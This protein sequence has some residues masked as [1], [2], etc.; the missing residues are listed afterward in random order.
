MSDAVLQENGMAR[1]AMSDREM[2][3]IASVEEWNK[4]LPS[5]ALAHKY[6]LI[7]RSPVSF[8]Q[9]TN[10]LFWA[11][12]S[13]DERLT[14]FG[15]SRTV[16]WIVGDCSTS[17]F[18][19][20]GSDSEG[21]MYGL[22]LTD[23]SVIADYQ[24]DVWRLATS[25][26][27]LAR[28]N[29]AAAGS[30]GAGAASAAGGA[31]GGGGGS[32]GGGAAEEAV[33][34]AVVLAFARK[35]LK[36]I[37]GF[38]QG[39]VKGGAGGEGGAEGA[40]ARKLS[41]VL[42]MSGGNMK[43]RLVRFLA[44]VERE[45]SR[46]RLLKKW[47]VE[48]GGRW[49]FQEHPG[50][51]QACPKF[52]EDAVVAALASYADGVNVKGLARSMHADPASCGVSRYM[53][54]TETSSG[55]LHVLDVRMQQRPTAYHF[56]N[57]DERRAYRHRFPHET[58]RFLEASAA[59]C[60][61]HDSSSIGWMELQEGVH[62]SA[63]GRYSVRD[64]SPYEEEYPAAVSADVKSK[65]KGFALTTQVMVGRVAMSAKDVD[66]AFQGISH[67]PGL[68]VWRLDQGKVV[69][70]PK[71]DH[72]KFYTRDIYIV[73]KTS[74]S[75]AAGGVTHAVHYWLGK[76]AS[77]ED[78]S[79]AALKALDLD[80]AVGG[81]STQHR[82]Q[83]G[84]ESPLFLSYFRPCIIPI[85]DGASG[86]R[87][88]YQVK[89]R[90]FLHVRQ[91]AFAR[92]S[93]N[94]SD[95]FVLQAPSKLYQ[96]NGANVSKQE[97]IR[98]ADATL[99]L[100]SQSP[101]GSMPVA[102]IDDGKADDASSSEFWDLFGGFAPIA[103]KSVSEEDVE[104]KAVPPTLYLVTSSGL[105]EKAK[106]P[107]KKNLLESSKCYLLDTGP[108]LFVWFGKLS[109][110]PDRRA[111]CVA[112][113]AHMSSRPPSVLVT[114]MS[115]RSE[116]AAFKAAF[117]EWPLAPVMGAG[118]GGASKLKGMVDKAVGRGPQAAAGAAEP[119]PP[120]LADVAGEMKK[121]AAG[122][123]E[124]PPP[125]LA[126]VAGEMQVWRVNGSNKTL[127]AAEE[128]GRFHG[129]DCYIVQYTFT[130]DRKFEY[131][132]FLW[133][134]RD[135]TQ[136]E[137]TSA[138]AVATRAVDA[139]RGNATLV[140]VVQGREPEQFISLFRT[141]LFFLKGGSSAS[142]KAKI[143]G[144]G[145]SDDTYDPAGVALFRVRARGAASTGASGAALF[146]AVQMDPVAKSLN[147]ED[148]FLLQTPTS[149]FLWLGNGSSA[150]DK[151]AVAAAA[152]IIKPGTLVKQ[153][154]EGKETSVFW[155]HLGSKVEYPASREG[156]EAAR[157]GRLFQV[158]GSGDSFKVL[159]VPGYSQD[160][161]ISED[162]MLL[163][164]YTEVFAWAGVNV[165]DKEKKEA[166]NHALRYV[167]RVA[168]T[169][170]RSKDTT[171]V[172]VVE[173]YEPPM[174]TALFP[175]WDHAAS[176]ALADPYDRKLA[177]LQGK[178]LEL[179]DTAKRRLAA[180]TH[181]SPSATSSSS[182][183]RS[184]S[185]P[186]SPSAKPSLSALTISPALIKG[187]AGRR[188]PS[189]APSPSTQRAAAMA[190]LTG[191]L[192]G[193]NLEPLKLARGNSL[194]G[195][196]HEA[197]NEDDD[198][199]DGEEEGKKGGGGSSDSA[200][201]AGGGAGGAGAAGNGEAAVEGV[202]YAFD[203]LIID[204]KNPIRGIDTTRRESYLSDADFLRIFGYDKGKFYAMPKWKQDQRKRSLG[205][206]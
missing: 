141:H 145:G 179:S 181:Q 32:G 25:I 47:C 123:A 163:D 111:A 13:G 168:A 52:E 68:D 83:Q 31:A 117:A 38:K 160:D 46:R 172:R 57:P 30:T 190:A 116:T 7:G 43:G 194:A 155:Q 54:L 99:L 62:P 84:H 98:A 129:G 100:K 88:L 82:E 40:N 187:L 180:L 4:G 93:L 167:D 105:Q 80:I 139:L 96:F 125:P 102:V 6:A 79:R 206:F 174:F 64:V 133:V 188:G 11:D 50:K 150:A 81:K 75:K 74:G 17:S 192:K 86:E 18:T 65:L 154:A 118:E 132:V 112:A 173:G 146:K 115:E 66:P 107:L 103:K 158:T 120:P 184:S 76:G 196:V 191:T 140:R 63:A 142:Y 124:P 149:L 200:A 151:D 198:S 55:E 8:F 185:T 28:E 162:V 156:K 2:H 109:T 72:G 70:V 204:S 201:A 12:L 136:E 42:L 24:Y 58:D 89:G 9:G 97:R 1:P 202:C 37:M 33:L 119:P 138:L 147:S 113:E 153:V 45:Y 104:A 35:Y 92:S 10:H 94:H 61:S 164:T 108:N 5:S 49:A 175:H 182:T 205:L 48:E 177:L 69:P 121:L 27:L 126:D 165:P 15:N 114:R 122:A 152:E 60:S 95:V 19:A 77:P 3:V 148:C 67:K 178:S 56:M 71:A 87:R 73:L 197:D 189:P 161:L 90:R 29:L 78:A 144:Q 183:P 159:E 128:V 16:T 44:I 110:V 23:E 127:V 101:N 176:A 36:T 106:A 203:R 193:E 171:V 199:E 26:V 166:L 20:S 195:S 41:Q 135:S 170:G 131:V 134:G 39:E 34:R 91:V 143:A 169:E 59:L 21:P 14:R 137:R 157:E 53:A 22:S 186:H 130:R 51:L 85:A